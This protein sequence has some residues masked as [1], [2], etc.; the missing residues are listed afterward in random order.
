MQKIHTG[1]YYSI[2][3]YGNSPK[4]L[5]VNILPRCDWSLYDLPAGSTKMILFQ[6]KTPVKSHQIMNDQFYIWYTKFLLIHCGSMILYSLAMFCGNKNA[7][8]KNN[9]LPRL[10]EILLYSRGPNK[11]VSKMYLLLS[12]YS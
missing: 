12:L 6:S 8:L 5:L 11:A 4:L 2:W 3:T 10:V 1:Y 9:R 7:K